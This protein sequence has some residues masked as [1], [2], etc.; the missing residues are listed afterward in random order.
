MLGVRK[1][2]VQDARIAAGVQGVL[3]G[4]KHKVQD[5]RIA[6]GVQ[7]VLGVRRKGEMKA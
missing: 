3:G 4:R 6:A 5:A 2:K 1:N 7:G